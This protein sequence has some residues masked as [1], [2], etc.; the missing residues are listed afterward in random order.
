M[1]IMT[2]Y[3]VAIQLTDLALRTDLTFRVWCVDLEKERFN[4]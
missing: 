3:R 2:N 4:A 1:K